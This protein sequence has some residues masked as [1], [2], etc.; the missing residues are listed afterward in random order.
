MQ[1]ATVQARDELFVAAKV[2][3]RHIGGG[4]SDLEMSEFVIAANTL[5]T[6]A[7]FVTNCGGSHSRFGH[8]AMTLR[9]VAVLCAERVNDAKLGHLI[10]NYP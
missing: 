6:I 2:V 4:L 3:D 9:D 1:T 8:V 5:P 7:A 10:R